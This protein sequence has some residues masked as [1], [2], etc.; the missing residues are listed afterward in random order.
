[1]VDPRDEIQSSYVVVRIECS[2]CGADI[3]VDDV[4]I[5]VRGPGDR[6]CGGRFSLP[7]GCEINAPEPGALCGVGVTCVECNGVPKKRKKKDQS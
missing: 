6:P 1:M 2:A 7:D 3:E 5:I 4:E